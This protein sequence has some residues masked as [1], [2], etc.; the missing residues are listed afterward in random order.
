MEKISAILSNIKIGCILTPKVPQCDILS[1]PRCLTNTDNRAPYLQHGIKR[2]IM[3]MYTFGKFAL[4]AVVTAVLAAC[5]SDNDNHS[6]RNLDSNPGSKNIRLEFAAQLN[7]SALQC[8]ANTET[9]GTA[10]TPPD[11]KYFGLYISEL[12]VATA[13]GDF[14]PVKLKSATTADVE[15]GISLLAFCGTNLKNNTIQG[16][17]DKADDYSRVRFTLGVPEKYNHLDA[18]KTRGI[19]AKEIAM[20]W[21]WTAGYKHARM[22]VAGWN[23]HLGSTACSG[24]GKADPTSVCSNGNRPTYSF[25]NINLAEDK[26]VLDYAKLVNGSDISKNIAG[27]PGCMSGTTDPECSKVFSALGLNLANGQCNNNDCDTQSWVS[28]AKK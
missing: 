20:H 3:H 16:T 15:R 7:S 9:V 24:N 26:I 23:I 13:S 18:T 17:V 5:G 22:D 28:T 11:I 6:D 10:N 21:N 25:R 12:E 8:G 27:A 14:V 19:L 1:H 2:K 4:T